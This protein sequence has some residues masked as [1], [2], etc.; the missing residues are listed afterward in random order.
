M[1]EPADT[2]AAAVFSESGLAGPVAWDVP[3]DVRAAAGQRRPRTA[4]AAAGAA[5]GGI[6]AAEP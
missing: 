4:G 3:G 5:Q 2:G 6:A 1:D